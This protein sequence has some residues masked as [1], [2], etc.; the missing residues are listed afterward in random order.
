VTPPPPAVDYRADFI[1]RDEADELLA[2]L[3]EELAW[4]V[5]ELKVFGSRVR[6]PRESAWYGDSGLTYAYS[7]IRLVARG[8]PGILSELRDRVAA[9][10]GAR[11]NAVLANRY[12]D[13][14]DAMGWHADDEP[15]LG[16]SPTV[17]AL[18]FGA[19]RPFDLKPKGGGEKRRW[20]PAHGSLLV[21]RPPTQAHYLH[22]VPKRRSARGDRINLTFRRIVS[23]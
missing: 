1:P 4:E 6:T 21:M 7:G 19:E 9:A 23:D 10:S 13:G 22:A 15:E 20:W 8:W 16:P 3:R 14:D 2:R 18:S 11:F 5:H 12:R 17:A